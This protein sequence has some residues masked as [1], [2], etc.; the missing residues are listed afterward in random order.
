MDSE[1]VHHV[2]KVVD[3]KNRSELSNYLLNEYEFAHAKEFCEHIQNSKGEIDFS[4]LS[5]RK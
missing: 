5:L 2:R 4:C 3:I 1:K